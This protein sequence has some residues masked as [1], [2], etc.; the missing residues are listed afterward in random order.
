MKEYY[1]NCVIFRTSDGY[2]TFWPCI[3]ND[4]IISLAVID[5]CSCIGNICSIRYISQSYNS[6]NVTMII[7]DTES[8]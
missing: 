8:G 6:P 7:D 1:K 4:I 3:V 2:S 5:H